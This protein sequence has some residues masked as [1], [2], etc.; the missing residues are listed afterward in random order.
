MEI[1]DIINK[2][3]HIFDSENAY[4]FH[5]LNGPARIY[6]KDGVLEYYIYGHYI[7]TNLSNK[8]FE[9]LKN[10]ELKKMVFE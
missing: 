6:L 4:I 9:R 1:I 3:I 5:S 7:G 8:E 2:E 10:I